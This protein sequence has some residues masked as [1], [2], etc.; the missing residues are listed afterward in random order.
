[1]A[2]R[3]ERNEQGN[4]VNFHGSSNP[5]YWNACLTAY[6]DDDVTDTINILNLP[7]QKFSVPLLKCFV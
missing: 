4:C 6:V 5:T 1:M 7:C 3:V 2:I